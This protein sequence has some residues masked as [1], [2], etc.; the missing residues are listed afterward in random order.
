MHAKSWARITH[1]LTAVALGLFVTAHL[2]NHLVGL[3]G[4]A[5]HQAYMDAARLVYRSPLVEPL[6]VASLLVQVVTGIAQVRFS[7]GKR[8]GLWARLQTVSGLYLAFFL[9]N[10]T[11]WV[12]VARIGYGLE[13]DFYLAATTLTVSPLPF[14]FAPYYAAGVFAVFVHIACAVRFRAAGSFGGRVARGLMVAGAVIAPL[15]V[16][17]FA[18]AFYEIKLP[19]QYRALIESIL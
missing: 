16:A 17:V 2:L 5:A 9:A 12:L 11:F 3:G 14:L 15:V 8:S 10:H 19:P 4:I 6:L 7:W 18:G 13:S 1:R